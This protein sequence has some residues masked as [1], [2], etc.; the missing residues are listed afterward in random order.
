MKV[1]AYEESMASMWDGFCRDA[2][3]STFLHTRNF[4]AYHGDRFKDQ[5]V[6]MFNEKEE[7]VGLLPAAED[8]SN[9][10]SLVSHPGSTFG[11]LIHQGGLKGGK[12]IDALK[13][14]SNHYA[15]LG[16]QALT[17]KVVPHIYHVVPS[18]DEVYALTQL[19]AARVRCDLTSTIDL[20]VPREISQ[21]RKRSL[22]KAQKFDLQVS[23]DKL[24]VGELWDLIKENLKKHA[25]EPTHSKDELEALVRRCADDI[26]ILVAIQ[27][28][29]AIA[30]LVLFSSENVVHAQYIDS[31]P[32]GNDLCALDLLLDHAIE[33]AKISG[34]R[35]F[36]FGISTERG[37]TYLNDSLYTFKSE[38]GGGGVVHEF[39]RLDV[40]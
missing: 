6:L 1:V 3:S 31:S 28:D 7:L 13:A 14:A 10:S 36:D 21:R 40:K 5:S 24:R 33:N 2:L 17:V 18:Q 38:F 9:S 8:P 19:G 11:G 27:E 22:K 23:Q 35:F 16:Y 30:G 34:A 39:Y 4:L 25:A 29:V 20:S 26:S 32:T 37:G 15:E 12:M